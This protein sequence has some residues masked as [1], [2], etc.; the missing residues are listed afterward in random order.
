MLTISMVRRRVARRDWCAS[1]HV[2]SMISVPGYSRTAL[3]NA[4]GPCSTIMLRHPIWQGNV[5]SRGGPL[6]SSG[7]CNVGITISV[8]RPGSP[9]GK[10]SDRTQEVWGTSQQTVCPLMELPLTAKSPR[11]ANNFWARFWLWTSL[12]RS[13][14]SSMNCHKWT[15][16][17]LS[18]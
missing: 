7:F 9:Y 10:G 13:G 12:K 17:L 6:G 11:Y 3:A 2:V 18:G 16:N 8:L 5:V 15:I 4:S 14:V 1:R